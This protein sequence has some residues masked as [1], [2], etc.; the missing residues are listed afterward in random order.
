MWA[1]T[2]ARLLNYPQSIGPD[3]RVMQRP[4]TQ[5]HHMLSGNRPTNSNRSRAFGPQG[6]SSE[7]RNRRH[8]RELCDE[9]LASYRVASDRDVI[10]DAER[11]DAR[12]IL[13]RF[14]PLGLAR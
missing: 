9:V 12:M 5:E 2:L 7:R 13:A 6:V 1:S 14:A 4:E 10:S 8:L 3:V 11:A